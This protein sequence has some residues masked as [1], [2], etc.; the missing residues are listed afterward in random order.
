MSSFF[1]RRERTGRRGAS[2][3]VR[4][5]C[6]AFGMGLLVGSFS[7]VLSA[8]QARTA[9]EGVY[10]EAQA[11][12]GQ[13]IYKT[14]CAACHGLRLTGNLA[15]ALTGDDFIKV[16]GPQPLAD[17]V[18]KIHKTMP[19]NDPGKLT[20]EQA[21]DLVAYLLQVAKFPSGG[22]ELSV[23]EETL[24][25]IT[26]AGP[27]APSSQPQ[28][29]TQ[30]RS[31]PPAGSLAQMM[32]GMLFPTSNLIFNVQGYDPGAK[33]PPYEPG[34]TAFSW[35]DW[36]V[37]IYSQWEILDYAALAIAEAAPLLLTPGRRCEN[38]KPVPVDRPD[39]VKFTQELAEAGRAA[40][41]AAQTR[42]QDTVIDATNLVADACLNCHVVYRDKPGGTPEDPSNKAARCV[43]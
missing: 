19:A 1:S 10:T 9:K 25:Q 20:R 24:K 41:K 33:R 5:G 36:G 34:S 8:G 6:C 4:A 38:G 7:L 37:G 16:W 22:A 14:T 18:I 43:P 31:F 23:D 27:Q 26:F 39:W 32:R 30:A 21:A 42:N 29:A 15:P 12:R 13:G 35:V 40:Y 11:T 28:V 17:L 3:K 2:F